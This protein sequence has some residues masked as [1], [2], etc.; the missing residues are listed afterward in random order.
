MG[1][2]ALQLEQ[3]AAQLLKELD[4]SAEQYSLEELER[5]SKDYKGRTAPSYNQLDTD[6]RRA[7][8]QEQQLVRK[9][10][11]VLRQP[12]GSSALVPAQN[13]NARLARVASGIDDIVEGKLVLL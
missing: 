8:E 9:G 4:Y 7:K 5:Y 1:V 2:T 6:I 10:S 3:V 11:D 12:K 13:P